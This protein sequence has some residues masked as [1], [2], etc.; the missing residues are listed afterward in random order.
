MAD[1]KVHEEATNVT[2]PDTL[3]ELERMYL[4][5][6]PT[7]TPAAAQVATGVLKKRIRADKFN[8]ASS[9][10]GSSVPIDLGSKEGLILTLTGNV[11]TFAL[12]TNGP[13]GTWQ[14]TIHTL[15]VVAS[16]ATRTVATGAFA[17]FDLGGSVAPASGYSIADGASKDFTLRRIHNG[18]TAVWFVDLL[19]PGTDVA[20]TPAGNIAATTVQAAI[21]ELDSEKQPLDAELTAIAGLTSAVDKSFYFT[22]PGAA[23]LMD[24]SSFARSVLDDATAAAASKTLAPDVQRVNDD[25]TAVDQSIVVLYGG[26]GKTLTMPAVTAN[27]IITVK[28]SSG[29]SWTIGR[30]GSDV[31]PASATSETLT[32]GKSVTYHY[33]GSATWGRIGA[34]S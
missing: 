5:Q 27:S 26:S 31:F 6:D 25:A 16:G 21:N 32:D 8:T 24:I 10:G 9:S 33:D 14:E 3:T 20:N 18:T 28:N 1:V 22:G 13:S 4:V 15:R 34:L 30:T 17:S 11:T 19:I 2:D 7:G 29:N 12:P 23:A